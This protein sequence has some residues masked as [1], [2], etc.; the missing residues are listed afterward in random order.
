M[1]RPVPRI[2][3]EIDAWFGLEAGDLVFTGTPEGV[4]P[5]APGD[6]LDLSL[7]GVPAAS[8]RFVVAR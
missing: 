1:L 5:I 8:A 3:R 7:D 4:G 6:V 2:L